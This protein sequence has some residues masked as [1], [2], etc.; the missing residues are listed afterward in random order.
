MPSTDLLP[1]RSSGGRRWTPLST[2]SPRSSCG[3]AWRKLRTHWGTSG[4]PSASHCAL[5]VPHLP[6]SAAHPCPIRIPVW[7]LCAPSVPHPRPIA[8]HPC[9]I[10]APVP[11]SCA[12]RVP[13]WPIHAPSVFLMKFCCE[14]TN[15]A[16]KLK[17]SRP[18][19]GPS[20]PHRAGIW[21]RVSLPPARLECRCAGLSDMYCSIVLE[22]VLPA[23]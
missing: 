5:S 19:F 4:A 9:P 14:S 22:R 2:I 7:P 3:R 1:R 16:R 15:G 13:L 10:L 11:H 20:L 18:D 12:M 8:A 23:C 17:G 21:A 6:C